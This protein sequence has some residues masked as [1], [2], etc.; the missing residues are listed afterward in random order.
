MSGS[1]LTAEQQ[2]AILQDKQT[3]AE[4]FER[5]LSGATS[6]DKVKKENIVREGRMEASSDPSGMVHSAFAPEVKEVVI[7]TVTSSMIPLADLQKLYVSLIED[8][9]K[10]ASSSEID[11]SVKKLEA[12]QQHFGS[13]NATPPTD[14]VHIRFMRF[15]NEV[16][17]TAPTPDID[18][19][20]E[21]LMSFE[22]MIPTKESAK[23]F[24]EVSP[25]NLFKYQKNPSLNSCIVA[26]QTLDKAGKVRE[27]TPEETA[28]Q[29]MLKNYI[30]LKTIVAA[31]NG[32][33]DA[34]ETHASGFGRSIAHSDAKDK[35]QTLEADIALIEKAIQQ[36]PLPDVKMIKVSDGR[37]IKQILISHLNP[38]T[39]YGDHSLNT[40]LVKM[41]NENSVAREILGIKENELVRPK[42]EEHMVAIIANL[43]K[44]GATYGEYKPTPSSGG[45]F[46][47]RTAAPTESPKP[48]AVD[49]K[50]ATAPGRRHSGG[51]SL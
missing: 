17:S 40:M 35:V 21:A 49:P 22:T 5:I 46:S 13:L 11:N 30:N 51:G 15:M 41:F 47:K 12:L 32:V 37:P 14:A 2:L 6:T 48:A 25:L 31:L 38:K 18:K 20:M 23:L 45:Q 44:G 50:P 24:A 42:K 34:Y 8:V 1:R 26:K 3:T 43:S 36:K 10:A 9:T 27:L 33:K 4:E 28:M 16:K 39:G 19:K 29:E 7:H